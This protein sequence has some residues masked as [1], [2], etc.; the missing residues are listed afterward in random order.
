[1]PRK[2]MEESDAIL[3]DRSEQRHSRLRA[4]WLLALVGGG[5][6]G[7][8]GT[9]YSAFSANCSVSCSYLS[10]CNLLPLFSIMTL[11]L[12][13]WTGYFFCSSLYLR[14]PNIRFNFSIPNFHYQIFNT[15]IKFSIPKS[16]FQYQN[17]IFNTKCLIQFFVS[18]SL[19]SDEK[20]SVKVLE[21]YSSHPLVIGDMF[22]EEDFTLESVRP[23]TPYSSG[24]QPLGL[25]KDFEIPLFF[26]WLFSERLQNTSFF[27]LVVLWKTSKILNFF[28][29]CSVK[30]FKILN[31]FFIGC[32]VKDFEI[33]LFFWLVV[34]CLNFKSTYISWSISW[35]DQHLG[36]S[37]DQSTCRMAVLL[38][39]I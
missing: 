27:W 17:Q 1:M 37:R 36:G 33:P 3:P 39:S 35:S 6:V 11:W 29:G 9:M 16:N 31:F 21:D 2:R 30:D 24:K 34:L 19:A 38:L 4:H 32:S 25:F 23:L 14:I 12:G 7:W 28:I 5:G 13:W 8:G 20:L 18:G 26:D 22:L 10:F 15:K